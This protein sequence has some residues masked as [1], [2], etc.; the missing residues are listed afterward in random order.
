MPRYLKE[1]N[2][3]CNTVQHL[4]GKT[5][6]LLYTNQLKFDLSHNLI[7]TLNLQDFG[8]YRYTE[9]D[10]HDIIIT[11]LNNNPLQCDCNIMESMKYFYN[12]EHN[13]IFNIDNLTCSAP[14]YLEAKQIKD[15]KENELLC[16]LENYTCPKECD[17]QLRLYDR[18]LLVN[19]SNKNLTQIPRLLSIKPHNLTGIELNLT[20]N[21]ITFLPH[22]RIQEGYAEC[23]KLYLAYNNITEIN[24]FQI[25]TNIRYL[26]LSH[27]YIKFL[28][29]DTIT[30]LNASKSLQYIFLKGNKWLCNCNETDIWLQLNNTKFL[31][32]N[33]ILCNNYPNIKLIQEFPNLCYQRKIIVIV[34]I[35]CSVILILLILAL[36]YKFREEIFIF[37]HSRWPKLFRI[38]END[39][40]ERKYDAFICYSHKDEDF[41]ANYLVPEL[42]NGFPPFKLCVHVRDF[43]VGDYIPDQIVQSIADSSRT[44]VVLSKNF[45]ESEWAKMEFKESYRATLRERRSKIIAIMY[46]DIGDI[47]NL[48]KDL[49]FYLKWNSYLR[50]GDVNFWQ[51]LRFAMPH[52]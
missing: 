31:D 30:I 17:C 47:S 50:W 33:E 21:Q 23:T 3:S 37:T 46:E 1:L 51:K 2:L 14:Q 4:S 9:D 8:Q 27:N 45:I 39:N 5:L 12:T 29:K 26:D 44:I 7:K 40:V 19:C 20:M 41:I 42:E 10:T 15:V 28:N 25:P 48:D 22:I 18:T 13:L 24:E 43:V 35:S 36:Y 16:S 49:K 11:N 34:L 6:E 38:N 52:K 32:A